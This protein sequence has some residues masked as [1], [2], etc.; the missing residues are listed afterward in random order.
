MNYFWTTKKILSGKV[1]TEHEMFET[2]FEAKYIKQNEKY[3]DK[4][5]FIKTNSR[6]E[7]LKLK[8]LKT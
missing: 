1:L 7:D 6:Y 4:D 5:F 3:F 8:D 2:F